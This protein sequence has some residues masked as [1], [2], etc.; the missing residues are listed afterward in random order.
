[1]NPLKISAANLR[2][3]PPRGPD[4]RFNDAENALSERRSQVAQKMA[5]RVHGVS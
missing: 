3:R 2:C 5:D 4:R 1:M